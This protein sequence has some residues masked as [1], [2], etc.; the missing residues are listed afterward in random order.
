SAINLGQY[1]D[2]TVTC[3]SDTFLVH[4]AFVCHSSTFFQKAC[5]FP[6]KEAENDHVQL[7]DEDP[8]MARRMI[9]FFYLGDYDPTSCFNIT[10][11]TKVPKGCGIATYDTVIHNRYLRH[12]QPANKSIHDNSGCACISPDPC[13][14]AQQDIVRPK[15]APMDAV[16]WLRE[17]YLTHIAQVTNPL[18]IHASMY[19]MADRY[20][21]PK[22]TAWSKKKF[23]D[24]IHDHWDSKD[25]IDAVVHIYDS[26]PD[27]DRGLRDEV[28]KALK[29]Y[30]GFDVA[31]VPGFEARLL[32]FND[33][34]LTMLKE[35]PKQD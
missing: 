26:T 10:N 23:A 25:F 6:G 28:V 22:L 29:K 11:L 9:T 30:C 15:W 1:S 17:F 16:P 14:N 21:I 4:K 27:T 2:L 8:D 32:Y 3:G 35:W 19:A 34:T 18:L 31:K 20:G 12:D 13:R 33:L 24:T 5:Q 7:H